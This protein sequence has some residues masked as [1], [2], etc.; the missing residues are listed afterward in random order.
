MTVGDVSKKI[1]G[2]RTTFFNELS[3]VKKSKASGV[4]ADS[5]YSPKWH[6]FDL[7]Q[8]LNDGAVVLQGE[9]NMNINKEQVGVTISVASFK[10]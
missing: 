9:S 4:S 10:D 8:F 1:H 5:V 7:L 3:K 6:Y 2:L